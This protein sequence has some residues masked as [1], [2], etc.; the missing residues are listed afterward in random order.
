MAVGE[1]ERSKSTS[2]PTIAEAPAGSDVEAKEDEAGKV[3][4]GV[5]LCER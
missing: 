4:T 1:H 3:G 2:D 5:E